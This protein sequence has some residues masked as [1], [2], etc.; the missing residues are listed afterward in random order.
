MM[1]RRQ[2]PKPLGDESLRKSN[3][4]GRNRRNPYTCRGAAADA[5]AGGRPKSHS[6]CRVRSLRA[7][8]LFTF[9]ILT[10]TV[11]VGTLA[12]E[13]TFG[14][15]LEPGMVFNIPGGRGYGESP[16][17]TENW[18]GLTDLMFQNSIDLKLDARGETGF[19]E[20]RLGVKQF[21]TA[22][23]FTG[24]A[25]IAEALDSSGNLTGYAAAVADLFYISDAYAFVLDVMRA[26]VGWSP[27]NSVKIT[28]GRQS[29]LTGYG[30]GWNP[31]DLVNPA[32]NPTDPDAELRGVDALSVRLSPAE[33]LEVKFYGALPSEGFAADYEDLMAGTEITFSLS[34][35]EFKLAGLWGGSENS[36][37]DSDAYPHAGAAAFFIDLFG[38]GFYGEG[39][40]RS[41]SRRNDPDAL[42]GASLLRN[43]PIFSGLVGAEYYFAAGPALAVEYFYNGEGWKHGSLED[44]V[45]ALNGGPAGGGI[46]E[47]ASLYTPLYYARHYILANLMI[48]W[49][50]RETTFNINA[51]ISPDSGALILTP[52]AEINLNFDGTLVAEIFYSGFFDFNESELNEAYLAPV[53]HAV[54]TSV[55]YYF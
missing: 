4:G 55:A 3:S 42:G 49:Y 16:L 31:V 26:N 33:R 50:A 18:M 10:A 25:Q 47:Y 37:D 29:F 20:L 23:L 15:I 11:C 39:A 32:K 1:R 6:S 38:V 8:T 52:S 41:R 34:S 21:P 28:L 46:G 27:S 48:P 13:T 14:G 2:I 5:A 9:L 44:Y 53:R 36:D 7:F 54:S 12:A 43:G 17:N 51:V 30:Y 45:T 35:A 19:M 22:D 40:V 24:T